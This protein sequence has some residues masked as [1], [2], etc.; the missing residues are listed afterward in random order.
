M[1][2][3]IRHPNGASVLDSLSP[4]QTVHDLRK[5]IAPIVGI[6]YERIQVAGGYPPKPYRNDNETLEAAGIKNGD[7]LAITIVDTP[8]DSAP[9]PAPAPASQP[10]IPP[11]QQPTQN[12]PMSSISTGNADAV[13]TNGGLLALRTVPD[14]NSCLFRALGYV[15][16]RDTSITQELRKAVATAI[17]QD[18][19]MYSDATL[20]QERTKYIDWIQKTSS[21][22]GAIEIA[23][24]SNYLNVEIDSID[25][26]TGRVDKFGEG[27]Y[28]ERVLIIYSGIHYDAV[29]LTPGLDCPEDFDQTRFS[30]GDESIINA[31][32]KLADILRQKR[33][34][35]DVAN[36]T[37]KCN[38]CMKGLVGE[39]DARDHAAATGHTHFVE[40]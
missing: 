39:K 13:E 12:A 33:K 2:L 40:Y 20:G 25:V 28:S 23:I 9:A 14:D 18:P 7:A 16:N 8:V 11:P 37:L 1:K 32:K 3:R 34:Y 21:W 31:A 35:T 24:L 4:E 5:A 27:S 10:S 29:A 26:Q 17:E 15:A 19:I 22:G 30:S 6:S 36:F 38:Q